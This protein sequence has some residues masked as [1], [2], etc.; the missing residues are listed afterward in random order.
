[1]SDAAE[2]MKAESPFW[3]FSL[4]FY[5]RPGISAACLVLQD[6]AG[7]DVNLL[8]FLLFLADSG[9]AIASEDVRRFDGAVKAWREA[10]VEPLRALRRR[11]KSGIEPVPPGDSEI[12]RN[13]IKR[14]ELEAERIEQG[15]LETLVPASGPALSRK[16]AARRNIAAYEPLL[17]PL[18]S[19]AIAAVL[20]AFD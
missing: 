18:P 13:Q 15:I 7:A 17:K 6:E 4:R 10:V 19:A 11:L 16:D 20:A 3:R 1:M 2:S 14:A 8:L 5:A 9:I 12:F